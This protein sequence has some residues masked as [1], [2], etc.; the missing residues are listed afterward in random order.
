MYLK[1]AEERITD[2][3]ETNVERMYGRGFVFTR[4]GK[5]VMQQTRSLRVDLS[6]FE[7]SSENRRVLARTSE[8][9]IMNYELWNGTFKYDW[10]IGKMAKDFYDTKFGP[11]SHKASQDKR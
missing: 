11:V 5:G 10:R 3:S 9:G 7:L 6:K 1:W 2:W 8:L 4:L